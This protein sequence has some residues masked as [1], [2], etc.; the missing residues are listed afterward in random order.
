MEYFRVIN[1]ENFGSKLS[2]CLRLTK[3]NF[4]YC[5]QAKELYIRKKE[6]IYTSPLN[7]YLTILSRY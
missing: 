7:Q 4:R 2:K 3:K 6:D 5:Y 1:Q